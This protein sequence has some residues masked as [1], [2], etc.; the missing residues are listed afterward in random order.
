MRVF[1]TVVVLV[2]TAT[3][4]RADSG[5]PGASFYAAGQFTKAK[6]S[7]ESDIALGRATPETYFWLGYTYLALNERDRAIAQFERY[8][9]DDPRNEDVLYALARTYADLSQMSLQ[10]IFSLDPASARAYQMRGIRFELEESWQEAIH[11]FEIAAKVDK[12]LSGPYAAI[13][14]IYAEE[15]KD[16]PRALAAYKS[17]LARAPHHRAAN[18]FL[19]RYH[20]SRKQP[21]EAR[22]FQQAADNAPKPAGDRATGI[23]LLDS[24]RPEES[25][26]YLLRWR[27]ADSSNV[28]AYYYLG[29]AFTD[30]KVKTINRL[31]AANPGSY[32]LHQILAE[33]FA[34]IH[35]NADAI[36]EY[37]KVLE[38][39]PEVP[40]VRYELARL[41]A[42]T[43]IEDTIP[44][45]DRELQMDPDHYLARALLGRVYTTLRQPDKA[46][47]LL[48]RALQVQPDL[49]EAQKSLGQ[50]W[51]AKRNFTRA[52]ALYQTVAEKAP[53]DEQIHFLLAQAWRGLGKAE[54][55]GKEMKLHQQTLRRLAEPGHSSDSSNK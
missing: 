26:A 47:P 11:Q 5:T 35:K 44:L 28:D 4:Q 9:R 31:K 46:I 36:A 34:S 32:R 10:R 33:S 15:L 12:S 2:I 8:L 27:A 40:G 16:E 51:A 43:Q 52:L 25:L 49:V 1:S 21:E 53:M 6:D 39:Q 42:E 54:E 24:H 20:L 41:M 45:L 18:E 22:K 30:L 19:T 23:S 55:A 14:R 38:N 48:E 7:L 50:A 17:E 29:E 13:G 3:L 37:R